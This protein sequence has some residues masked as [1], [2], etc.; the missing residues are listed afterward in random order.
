[1]KDDLEPLEPEVPD[2]PKA[3]KHDELVDKWFSDHFPNSPVAR[4]TE[5]Y[6]H[7]QRARDELKKRLNEI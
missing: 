1:M 6:N 3:G 2:S 7:A 4:D 5:A